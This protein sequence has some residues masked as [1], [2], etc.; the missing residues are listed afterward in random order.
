MPKSKKYYKEKKKKNKKDESLKR[1]RKKKPRSIEYHNF[2]MSRRLPD[3]FDPR[4]I[5]QG[6]LTKL[7]EILEYFL[8]F[9]EKCVVIPDELKGK[10]GDFDEGIKRTKKLIEKLKAGK[11]DDIFKDPE[12]WNFLS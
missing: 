5:T 11:V 4:N 8:D 7:A 1:H 3:S 10:K 12:E 6:H 2:E 9:E